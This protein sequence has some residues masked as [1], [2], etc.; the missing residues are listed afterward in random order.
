MPKVLLVDDDEFIHKLIGSFLRERGYEVVDMYN[1]RSALESLRET[2]PDLVLTD[3]QMPELDGLEL[4]KRLRANHKTARLP[5]ILF[6]SLSESS[7]M[8]KG[9]AEGADEYL[10]KPFELPILVAKMETLLRRAGAAEDPATANG[11]VVTVMHG[12]GGVGATTVGVNLAATLSTR[13]AAQVA[14]LDLNLD[15]ENAAVYLNLRP[16]HSLADLATVGAGGVDDEFFQS[17]FV[18][19]HK[20]SRL[21]LVVGCD[22]PEKT[23]LVGVPA[24]QFAIDRLRAVDDYVVIDTPANFSEITLAAMDTADV[25]CVVTSPTIPAMKATGDCLRVLSKLQVPPEKV[26][27]VL[28]QVT[29]HGTDQ[30][31]VAKFFNRAPDSAISHSELFDRSANLG[32][33]A[34]LAG[35]DET[36]APEFNALAE[37]LLARLSPSP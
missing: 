11:K 27:L 30:Q 36:P 31:A 24:V 9:Y 18:T 10:P 6:S 4:T 5:I 37:V 22:H 7:H 8:L 33:P 25:I 20:Q 12:K 19:A 21:H 29:P 35:P 32:S 26:L 16:Q 34:V 2:S 15:Y 23:E 3:V 1:G 13:L 28:N 14:L 17:N